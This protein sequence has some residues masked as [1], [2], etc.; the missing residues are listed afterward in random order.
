ML[1]IFVVHD[2]LP[3]D[4]M[5]TVHDINAIDRPCKTMAKRPKTII[6]GYGKGDSRQISPIKNV[7]SLLSAAPS[8]S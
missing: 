5:A 6:L 4:P 3:M 7:N 2:G 1:Q 8:I